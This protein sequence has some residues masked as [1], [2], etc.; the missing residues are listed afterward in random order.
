LPVYERPHYVILFAKKASSGNMRDFY[1]RESLSF[2]EQRYQDEIS[3]EDIAAFCNL[4]RS[5]LGKVFRSVLDTSPQNFLIRF[6]INKSCELMK[7][8]DR[9]I[10]EISSMVGYPNQFNFSRAF[11]HIM[12]QSPREWRNEH[13]L[14]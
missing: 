5:Y 1:I 7:I 8:T 13:K 14:C 9:T 2:I 4:D 3:V 10:S 6:R 11:K 12:G